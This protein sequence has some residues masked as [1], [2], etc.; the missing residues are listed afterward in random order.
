MNHKSQNIIDLPDNILQY[1]SE[2]YLFKSEQ[3]HFFGLCKSWS[4]LLQSIRTIDLYGETQILRFLN[5]SP[6]RRQVLDMVGYSD[7][8]VRKQLSATVGIQCIKLPIEEF[9]NHIK[10]FYCIQT[11]KDHDY[12]KLYWN[13]LN[14]IKQQ[15]E[16]SSSQNSISITL[17]MSDI[18]KLH[19][20]VIDTQHQVTNINDLN[21]EVYFASRSRCNED[22]NKLL[23]YVRGILRVQWLTD[24]PNICFVT[25][26]YNSS[27]S[28]V[29][30]Q[31]V[32]IN[33]LVLMSDIPIVKLFDTSNARSNKTNKDIDFIPR[34]QNLELWRWKKMPQLPWQLQLSNIQSV[35]LIRVEISDISALCHIRSILISNCQQIKDMSCLNNTKELKI[36]GCWGIK[37]FPVPTGSDQDWSL[38]D[39]AI[40]NKHI[41]NYGSIKKLHFYGCQSL[42][43]L[44]MLGNVGELSIDFCNNIQIFPKPTRSS[45][46]TWEYRRMNEVDVADYQGLYSILIYSC[47][48]I[49]NS[50]DLRDI[51][52][53][54]IQQCDELVDV[55]MLA[56]AKLVTLT[57]C[58]EITDVSMLGR[59]EVLCLSRC[60]KVSSIAGLNNVFGKDAPSNELMSARSKWFYNVN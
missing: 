60:P 57:D 52:S 53:V 1:L 58:P 5:D 22:K 37:Y 13:E 25:L 35:K 39:L 56:N 51:R 19:R 23:K 4:Y 41:Q 7:N 54:T 32:D 11:F 46:Q 55:S 40:S 49:L 17:N 31:T 20:L 9:R 33:S 43:D 14:A 29:V 3:L 16:G 26:S 10:Y 28:E 18:Y 42:T 38:S 6:F 50:H 34:L 12:E 21:D 30:M 2:S 44:T 45:M 48:R 15:I 36:N 59:V 47:Y 27:L 8:T 24:N